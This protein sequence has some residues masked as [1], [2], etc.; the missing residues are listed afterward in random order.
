MRP[1]S[2]RLDQGSVVRM[3]GL[4]NNYHSGLI[5]L[6]I[7]NITEVLLEMIQFKKQQLIRVIRDKWDPIFTGVIMHDLA[8]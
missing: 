1:V 2:V 4:Q 3:F 8:F 7:S 5:K 6:H